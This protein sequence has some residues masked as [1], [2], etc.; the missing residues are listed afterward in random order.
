MI[1][2]LEH[3]FRSEGDR[4]VGRLLKKVR[5]IYRI[6]CRFRVPA[7]GEAKVIKISAGKA[8]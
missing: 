2:R 7:P 8:S 1:G 6:V 3:R 5:R 4:Q